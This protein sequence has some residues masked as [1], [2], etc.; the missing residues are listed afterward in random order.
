MKAMI[1]FTDFYD[2]IDFMIALFFNC[3]LNNADIYEIANRLTSKVSDGNLAKIIVNGTDDNN[4]KKLFENYLNKLNIKLLNP[5]RALVAKIFYYILHNRIDL[6][7]GIKFLVDYRVS[8][9][10][11]AIE[12]IGDDVGISKILGN[13]YAIDDGDLRN[14]KDIEAAINY[15]FRDMKQYVNDYLVDFPMNNNILKDNKQTVIKAEMEKAKA[16][17]LATGIQIKNYWESLN[18]RNTD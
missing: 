2:D 4:N 3:M 12:Y 7:E 9:F 14:K 8:N 10:D 16:K 18:N 15:I 1:Q 6:Y 13:F 5:K 11:D 17:A